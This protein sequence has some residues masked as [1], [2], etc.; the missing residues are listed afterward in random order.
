MRSL[1]FCFF[2]AL[3]SVAAA[4]E[5]PSAAAIASAHPLA[6]EAGHRILDAG[7]NAFDA[8]VAVSAVLAV[9][10]PYSSGIGGGGF[11]LLHRARDGFE[12]MVDG[13][14]RAPLAAH[15][16]LYLDESGK[17]KPGLSIDGPLAA[18]IP[19]EPAALVH[20]AEKYGRL[21]LKTSLAPAIRLARDGFPVD[22]YYLRMAGWR[23]KALR[24][25]G[26]A[27]NIFLNAGELP[28][29]DALLRQP[30][31]SRTLT[32]LAEKGREGFYQ[33]EVASRL[34]EGVRQA[35]GIWTLKDLQ[36]YRIV[37][38]EPVRGEYRGLKIT[39]A[40]LPSSGG[41]VLVSMLNMLQ[42]LGL[43]SADEA[44][45][46]HLIIE[47]MRRAYRDRADYMGDPDFVDVPVG[48]LIHP[49]YAAG[50]ARDIQ[51]DRATP[52]VGN[53]GGFGEG[54]DTTHF[55]IL[56]REGNRVSATLS[57]N[58][59]FGSGFIPPGTGVLLNDE[60]DDFSARPGM[61]NVYGLVGGEANAIAPGKRM[62]SSMSPTFV[63]SEE[64]VAILGTPGGSR[65]ITMLL[66][67]ILELADGKGPQ[68]WVDRPR[69]HH[70]YLPDQ[71]QFEPGA[72][73]NGLRTKLS[74]M[75]H[76][77]KPLDSSYGNMQAV[78]WNRRSGEVTAASDSRGIGEAQ[79]R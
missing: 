33:G 39:S 52:S 37:E 71:V 38:R 56:D 74:A 68:A 77:L 50:L 61:P 35:G 28:A 1:F 27:K 78:Y 34:V 36:E 4:L 26:D 64:G 11:W 44:T 5:K 24:Q 9:V 23:L 14:E 70:Q 60:M 17:V 47:T 19:G 20:I 46:I 63:A 58:Y 51:R 49:W 29:A 72:L 59:P 18:G 62:L 79:V 57:I 30:D 66:L 31:L 22:D 6:T 15:R 54:R 55:S 21:P 16:D 76:S 10:E 53:I 73:E 7:G 12:V 41:I 42:G 43:E 8:A 69:F 25:G 3:S 32:A 65:I 48:A 13:R 75:G 45:R 2:V 40:A 67:G